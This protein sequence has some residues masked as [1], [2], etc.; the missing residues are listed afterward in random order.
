MKIAMLHWAY[1]P[2]IGGVETHL[3]QLCPALVRAGHQVSVLTGSHEGIPQL[4]I[5]RGVQIRRVSLMNL[6]LLSK[7]VSASLE[8]AIADAVRSYFDESKPDLIH[9]HNLHYF[10]EAHARVVKNEANKR[11]IPI[12]L[13]A[14]NV[15]ND[16]LFMN[17]TRIG[18]WDHTIAVSKFI[19]HALMGYGTPSHDVTVIHHGIDGTPFFDAKPEEAHKLYPQLR[20]RNVI[21]HPARMHVDKG[22]H[23]VAQAFR[24]VK[25]RIPDALLVMA[26]TTD[27]VDWHNL[28]EEGMAKVLELLNHFGLQRDVFVD[29]YP[30]ER[31]PLM[32]AACTL[33]VYP[34][35]FDEPFGLAT[36]EAMSAGKSIIVTPRGGMSE[37]IKA[38]KNGLIVP[39]G[40]PV[41]LANAIVRLLKHP[42]VASRMGRTGREMFREK[43]QLEIMV[44]DTI[45]VYNKCLQKYQ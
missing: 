33:V 32:Y 2:V 29:Q 27:V 34:S 6:G 3:V 39:S 19:K 17:I 45:A 42:E 1:P 22:S 11:K 44:Q 25:R 9:V 7:K 40:D 15:W 31:M 43:Y 13:T 12:V 41:S 8:G 30:V 10:S 36:I 37:I 16:R 26:G 35:I 28:Q 20:G 38:R 24:L 18:A 14:H 5:D 23:I 21:F 4:Y